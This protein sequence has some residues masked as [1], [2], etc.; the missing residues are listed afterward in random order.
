[1]LRLWT[2]ADAKDGDVL[3][4]PLPK[5]Y[6]NG[7]QIFIFKGINSRDYVDDC[8]EYYCRICEGV[9]YENKN[10][11]MGTVSSPLY[12]ATKEQ[13]NILFLKMREAGYE[14]DSEKKEVEEIRKI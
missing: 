12:P 4:C 1:M 11:Y 7:E 8:I 2:I 3:V 14:W 13:R 5:G 9:F 10:G 6:E